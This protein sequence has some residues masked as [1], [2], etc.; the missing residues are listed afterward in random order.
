MYAVIQIG[1]SQFKVAEGDVIHADRVSVE[2]GKDIQCDKVLLFAKGKD[3]RVGQPYL[4][5]VK[6]TAKVVKHTRG[7]KVVSFK[8][9]RRKDSARKIGHR[10]DL[11]ELN[12]TKIAA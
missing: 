11:S 9:R 8:Y 3:V 2:E 12:I 6:V 5:D 10:D 1:S 7:E 4:K